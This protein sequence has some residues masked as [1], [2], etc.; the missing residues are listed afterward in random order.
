MKKQLNKNLLVVIGVIA[1]ALIFI[2]NAIN[3]STSNDTNEQQTS[4]DNIGQQTSSNNIG[5]QTEIESTEK[6]TVQRTLTKITADYDG[7]RSAGVLLDNANYDITVFG[8]YSDGTRQ[9]LDDYTINNPVKL[10]A[11]KTSTVTISYENL[12]CSLSV[13]CTTPTAKQ[14]KNKCKT[15]PYKKLARTPDKYEGK[16]VKFTGKII[17]VLEDG[18]DAYY[19]IDVTKGKYGI[20]DDTV[21]V[22][23]SGNSDKR[24]LE[25]DIVTF[26]GKSEGLHTYETI[27][28]ASVTIPSVSAKYMVL[29]K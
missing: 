3:N 8:E 7:S 12:K 13:T 16:K 21:Y 29:K 25:D 5:Q 23:Y 6:N 9:V 15:I 26:Y 4:S 27:F 28:G 22:E 1:V 17:Q 18:D 11:G 2:F 10:K 14:Y 20:W 19:R 24:F